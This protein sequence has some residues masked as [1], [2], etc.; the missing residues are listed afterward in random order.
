MSDFAS[1][2]DFWDWSVDEEGFHASLNTEA[3]VENGMRNLMRLDTPAVID[4]LR[5]LGYA[6]TEP[7]ED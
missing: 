3:V 4:F 2:S 5:G 6:V 7:K 1:D